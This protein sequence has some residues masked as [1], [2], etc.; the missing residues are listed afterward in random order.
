[1]TNEWMHKKW[2]MVEEKYCRM[3]G[4]DDRVERTILTIYEKKTKELGLK[5]AWREILIWKL[6]NE[7]V[8]Y[9]WICICTVVYYQ[10]QY[11]ISHIG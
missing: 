1:M 7:Y 2:W 6:T 4:G 11:R 9:R 8:Y 10:Y 3:G 5:S